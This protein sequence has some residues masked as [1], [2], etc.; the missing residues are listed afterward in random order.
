MRGTAIT[1]NVLDPIDRSI[2]GFQK[3]VFVYFTERDRIFFV[4]KKN[5]KKNKYL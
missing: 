1:Q 4:S 5:K 2:Q 3:A